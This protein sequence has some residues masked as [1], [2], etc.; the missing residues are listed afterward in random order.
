ML[1]RYV[2]L[3]LLTRQELHGYRVKSAFQEEV[4]PS[5]PLSFGQ[6]YQ[7]L[8]D[9]KRRALVEARFDHGGGHIGRWIYRITPKGR[10]ILQVWLTRA[11]R[12]PQPLRDEIFI[13]L[14]TVHPLAS[15]HAFNQLAVQQRAYEEHLESLKADRRSL[16]PLADGKQLLRSLIADAA[17]IHAEA[18]LRWL[19]HCLMV[20][21]TRADATLP[22]QGPTLSNAVAES[23]PTVPEGQ[24]NDGVSPIRRRT[25][26]VRP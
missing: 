12:S 6:I 18:H 22:G 8:K 4:G 16:E 17:V 1:V 5:W 14:L 13:R 20:L 15:E 9:L 26:R 10:R 19:R 21:E 23:T 3:G 25:R 7:A 11:P 2:I 24:R